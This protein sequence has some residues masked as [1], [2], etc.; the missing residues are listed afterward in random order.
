M[1][2]R[3]YRPFP[4]KLIGKPFGF[5]LAGTLAGAL[6]GWMLAASLDLVGGVMARIDNAKRRT[7]FV[8][9]GAIVGAVAGLCLERRR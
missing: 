8:P 3:R 9:V 4:M 6:A 1:P 2:A 7:T 5:V